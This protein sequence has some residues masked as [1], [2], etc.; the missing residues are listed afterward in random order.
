MSCPAGPEAVGWLP[1]TPGE[2]GLATLGSA[3]PPS[4]PQAPRA[5]DPGP[6][7]RARTAEQEAAKGYAR[8]FSTRGPCPDT[9]IR[10]S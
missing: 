6:F 2:P 5:P 9:S 10:L 3:L 4:L 8:A 1:G 7:S